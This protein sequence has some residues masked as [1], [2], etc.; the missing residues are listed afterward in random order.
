MEA[1][2][3]YANFTLNA[4][5]EGA[6]KRGE[7]ILDLRRVYNTIQP[8]SVRRPNNRIV[9]TFSINSVEVCSASRGCTPKSRFNNVKEQKHLNFLT[10]FKNGNRNIKTNKATN[11][12]NFVLLNIKGTCKIGDHFE[13]FA[14]RVP[15]SGVVG[16]KIGLSLQKQ[17]IVRDPGADRKLEYLGYELE[18]LVFDTL[19]VPPMRPRKLSAL[20]IQGWNLSDPAGGEKPDHRL[21]NFITF[22]RLLDQQVGS[23]FLDYEPRETKMIPRVNFKPI[24]EGPTIGITNWLMVDFTGVRTVNE[25]RELSVVFY[26]AY[27]RLQNDIV[28]NTNYNGPVPKSRRKT[29]NTKAK[30]NTPKN[31]NNNVNVPKWNQNKKKFYN[32]K[33][34]LFNDKAC[35][36][37]GKK[38][39]EKLA[40]KLQVNP[41]GFK[42]SVCDRIMTKLN[43]SK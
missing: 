36:R 31:K 25:V 37:L 3:G 11:N 21:K 18:K 2:I 12:K 5:P 42:A 22:M 39:I 26:N 30:K 38:D 27:R 16:I 1:Y 24:T 43:N 8:M 10:V 40:L 6:P 33:G 7:H 23:H 14:I 41:N 9:K 29:E 32:G 20:S 19:P 34:K 17:I 28:W 4:Y 15:K 13:N 35:M